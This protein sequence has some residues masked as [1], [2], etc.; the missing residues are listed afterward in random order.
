MRGRSRKGGEGRS[1]MTYRTCL[2]H[3]SLLSGGCV[4]LVQLALPPL[5]VLGE[6]AAW[7]A[8]ST[9]SA[10][11]LRPRVDAP[12]PGYGAQSSSERP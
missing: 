12:V 6:T 10:S 8:R 11:R 1:G 3:V 7:H 4:E 9:R 2:I 5:F